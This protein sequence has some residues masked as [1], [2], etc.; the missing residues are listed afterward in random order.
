MAITVLCLLALVAASQALPYDLMPQVNNGQ[1]AAKGQF[2]YQ[3]YILGKISKWQVVS[4]CGGAIISENYVV[5]SALCLKKNNAHRFVVYAGTT[6]LREFE[7]YKYEVEEFIYPPSQ[8]YE[9]KEND[10]A[11]L[12]LKKSFDKVPEIQSIALPK[13]NDSLKAGDVAIVSGWGKQEGDVITDAYLR[14]TSVVITDLDECRKI[15]EYEANMIRNTNICAYKRGD[16][17]GPC[18]DDEGGP[19]TKDGE[20]V[21]IISWSRNDCADGTFPFI[22]TRVSSYLD[23]IKTNTV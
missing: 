9:T 8:D 20:L 19:L 6:D 4:E 12:K 10:I 11:L 13:K 15:Y 2:P 16:D 5:T 18:F 7:G 17:I 23:W 22:Y 14:Y 21:G 1:I 3:V